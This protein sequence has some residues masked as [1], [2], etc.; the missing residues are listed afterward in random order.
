MIVLTLYEST[1]I[2]LPFK[3][4]VATSALVVMAPDRVY[5]TFMIIKDNI[6]CC[7]LFAI[8]MSCIHY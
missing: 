5:C 4:G 2:H 7:V 1:L 6:W 3:T 8:G